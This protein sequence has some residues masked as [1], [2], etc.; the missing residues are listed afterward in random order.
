MERH[1][2]VVAL[3]SDP[4]ELLDR[5]FDAEREMFQRFEKVPFDLR[6]TV[7]GSREAL[8]SILQSGI[9]HHPRR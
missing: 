4:D 6:V 3:E 9:V 2:V 7:P 8:A 1:C 5:I